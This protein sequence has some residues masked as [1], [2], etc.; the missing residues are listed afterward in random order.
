VLRAG[1][2][3]DHD[4]VAEDKGARVLQAYLRPAEP[5]APPSH[6][7]HPAARGWV[8][9]GRADARLWVGPAADAPDGQITVAGGDLVV[10]WRLSTD[11][12]DW[13]GW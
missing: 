9:L 12:P 4:E 2:G 13:A 8:D 11:R 5:S 7:V 3:L 1:T 10:V 6:V